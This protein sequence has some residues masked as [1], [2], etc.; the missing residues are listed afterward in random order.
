LVVALRQESEFPPARTASDGMQGFS[1]LT[2]K[3]SYIPSP[4]PNLQ[5]LLMAMARQRGEDA[6][7]YST[8]IAAITMPRCGEDRVDQLR[9]ELVLTGEFN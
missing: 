3:V 6:V 2:G 9:L 1:D 8:T 5:P 4:S 7:A